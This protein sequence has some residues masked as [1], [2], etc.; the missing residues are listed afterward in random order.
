MSVQTCTTCLDNLECAL[1]ATWDGDL[2]HLPKSQFLVQGKS[3]TLSSQMTWDLEYLSSAPSSLKLGCNF[4]DE[5][6]S[7]FSSSVPSSW[8]GLG[9]HYSR[10]DLHK[11]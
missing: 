8:T 11:S 4:P 5:F 7:S 2:E 1:G 9:Q 3:L 10:G 6:S